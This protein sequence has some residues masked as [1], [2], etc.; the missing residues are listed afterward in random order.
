MCLLK[1]PCTIDLFPQWLLLFRPQARIVPT[2]LHLL[3]AIFKK[4]G[5][6]FASWC[7]WSLYYQI[8]PVQLHGPWPPLHWA[9]CSRWNSLSGC[10]D[11]WSACA[12]S[13]RA[14]S[15]VS[16]LYTWPHT[17]FTAQVFTLLR[18]ISD[19]VSGL[20]CLIGRQT[21]LEL[22]F[23]NHS[24]SC[25]TLSAWSFGPLILHYDWNFIEL[26]IVWL[27]MT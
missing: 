15:A 22:T 23:Q 24:C 9:N 1:P 8:S 10:S 5:I 26:D 2:A 4:F 19:T 11:L 12:H 20:C 3:A 14:S 21:W 27:L 17:P 25:P 13:P 16:P 7:Y 18:A 6:L